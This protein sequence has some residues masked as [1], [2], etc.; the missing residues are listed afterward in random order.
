MTK[1]REYSASDIKSLMWER[2]SA[3]SASIDLDSRGE[4][5][6]EDFF[7]RL[8]NQGQK[9]EVVS[10]LRVNLCEVFTDVRSRTKETS[11]RFMCR[12]IRL[13]DIIGAYDCK[14]AL[15]LILFEESNREWGKS[16][17]ELQE[18]AARALDGMPKGETDFRYW[19][20]LAERLN[21]SLPYALNALIE[22][23]PEKGLRIFL[24]IYQK[25]EE[26]M[27]DIA[28]WKSIIQTAVSTH[29]IK[30][31]SKILNKI[32]AGNPGAYEQFVN[33]FG[34]QELSRIGKLSISEI[35]SYPG[36]LSV[37]DKSIV[38]KS[39]DIIPS[40]E[41]KQRFA[42]LQEK[43]YDI[44]DITDSQWPLIKPENVLREINEDN[45]KWKYFTAS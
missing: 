38:K 26:N 2:L 13:C 10:A 22:I 21:D 7:V 45:Y 1:E 15:K 34:L 3:P 16:L 11:L 25:C 5:E 31:I 24:S 32:Y 44:S 17:E 23:D 8:Y 28:D 18:L 30:K 41:Q 37:A 43:P 9:K 19:R 27:H 6:P 39:E 42:Y 29:G 33:I 35:M 20:D 12:A 4:E 14:T 40:Y 36:Q